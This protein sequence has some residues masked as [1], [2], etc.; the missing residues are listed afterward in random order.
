MRFQISAAIVLL[1]VSSVLAIPVVVPE[2][3]PVKSTK[4]PAIVYRDTESIDEGNTESV[5]FPELKHRD[6][7]DSVVGTESIFPERR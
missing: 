7:D 1:T 4:G 2:E 6:V 5:I 3:N